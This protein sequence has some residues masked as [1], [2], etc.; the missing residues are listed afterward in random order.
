MS[1]MSCSQT[2]P[3]ESPKQWTSSKMTWRMREPH[4]ALLSRRMPRHAGTVTRICAASM[5]SSRKSRVKVAESF[6]DPL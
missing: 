5:L 3:P 6:R 2:S 4:S 1:R